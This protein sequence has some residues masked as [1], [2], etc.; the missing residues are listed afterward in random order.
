MSFYIVCQKK[1]SNPRMDIRICQKKCDL[2]DD[3]REY[4]AVYQSLDQNNGIHLGVE[5]QP[6]ALGA[7]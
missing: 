5:S 3:C 1:R 7:A 2:K 6:V 4:M